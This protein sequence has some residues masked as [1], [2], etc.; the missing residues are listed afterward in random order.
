MNRSITEGRRA[1]TEKVASIESGME[2][3]RLA[4]HLSA[5]ADGEADASQLRE[6]RPHLRSCL[7]CRARLREYRTVPSRVAALAPPALLAVD[8]RRPRP[9]ARLPGVRRSAPRRTAPRRSAS[10]RTRPPRW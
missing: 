5:L 8:R 3:R 6:L 10:A 9:G 4:P 2:C 7:A 1:F